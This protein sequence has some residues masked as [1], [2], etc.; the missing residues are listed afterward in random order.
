MHI[1]IHAELTS[2]AKND[3]IPM[4]S[5]LNL[6]DALLLTREQLFYKDVDWAEKKH[7]RVRFSV[8]PFAQN[9]DRGK[10]IRGQSCDIT[11][12]DNCHM[13]L[14]DTP[15]GDLT[16][17]T[18]M[19]AL[20]YDNN[21]Y[22]NGE[23]DPEVALP[24]TLLAAYKEFFPL[25]P[26]GCEGDDC[27]INPGVND[28][29]NID[30]QQAYGFFSFPLKYR[31]R[32]VR[33]EMAALFARN[34]G[35]RI[36]T[37]VS[38]IR[39]VREETIDLT[40]CKPTAACDK[41]F[42]PVTDT[43]SIDNVE[44]FLMDQFETIANE[45]GYDVCDFVKTSM[46]E[47]RF[48]VF[49]RQAFEIN[50][51]ADSEWAKF[52]LIPYV[53]A[54][55]SVSP[56]TKDNQHK[57]FGAPFGNNTHPSIGFTTGINLDFLETIEIGGEVGYTHFFKKS[58]C[59]PVPNNKFQMN[60]YPFTTNVSVSPGDNWYF[61]ARIAAYHFIDK[62]SMYFEWF[63][64]DHQKD[65]ICVVNSD[66]A[67]VPRVLECVSTF[68]TKLGN[69]GFN[70]DLSPNIGVGFLWQIPFSQRN[71]YRSSTLMASFNVTF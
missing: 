15:L 52:L 39:Q 69:A 40:R 3:A 50:K 11:L 23:E 12:V 7:N 55:A 41:T 8:S 28:E 53:E 58:F 10:T 13:T 18:D 54:G 1:P 30:P 62:L 70:Y 37:G 63:V 47:I 29:A 26:E 65:D 16:G 17:R 35:V 46:E 27:K 14:T 66:P 45:S 38:T 61:G 48:N 43:L 25:V 5:T 57:F 59:M 56:G 4:F 20:L 36:Q 33:F 49:W 71:S 32:G 67:F 34:F 31:K 68:K 24:P 21:I 19:I 42:E 51:D 6:D 44:E 22:P 2:L 9:A 64:L 60:L